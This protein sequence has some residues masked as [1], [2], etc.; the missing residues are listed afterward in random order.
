MQAGET[1]RLRK[2]VCVREDARV[3]DKLPEGLDIDTVMEAAKTSM[4]GNEDPGF[5]LSCGEE[6]GYVEP[7]AEHYPCQFCG[8]RMVF[9]A[10]WIFVRYA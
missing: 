8:E 4:F 3:P 6:T 2:D 9:G 10:E 5:C 7:D 1:T